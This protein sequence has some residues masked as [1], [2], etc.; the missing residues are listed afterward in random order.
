MLHPGEAV[1][2]AVSG[3][4][5]SMCLL[6]VL[7]DLQY[8]VEIA[9]F[10]HQ[11][12][13][14]RS[15]E[16]AAFVRDVAQALGVPFHLESRAIERDAAAAGES[17]EAYA[18]TA[19]YLFLHRVA[20]A[21]GIAAIATGHQADD[22]AETVIMRL[23]RGTWP[24]G[25]ASIPPVR[26]LSDG[27]RIVRPLLDCSRDEIVAFV[28]ERNIGYREDESNAHPRFLR[29]RLRH[30][31]LPMLEREYNPRLRAA[32]C[33]LAEQ[34]QDVQQFIQAGVAELILACCTPDTIDR[35][36]F[37]EGATVCQRELLVDCAERRE[38]PIDFE[39][40]ERAR[41][42]VLEGPSH[43]SFDFG[44]GV[45][46]RNEGST[47][48]IRSRDTRVPE[49]VHL[50]VPGSVEAFGRLFRCRVQG[51]ALPVPIRSICDATRQVFDADKLPAT[52]EVRARRDG[53][54]FTPLGMTAPKK[55]KD[56]FIDKKVPQPLRDSTPLLCAGGGVIWVVGHGIDAR[57]AVTTSTRRFLIIEVHD[58]TE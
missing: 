46:L 42:F 38:I 3:G 16:D 15:A 51:Q 12:R 55:L 44:G 24:A 14:G 52:L 20:K 37:A 26:R 34:Q 54:R 50:T 43:K 57:A 7:I 30:E 41:R 21:S 39:R 4:V 40:I 18:R 35:E 56:Y 22:R 5:D 58:A 47:T 32:L 11:T 28:R 13:D 53:D 2:V 23:L 31:L 27:E 33:R 49:S 29:N 48:F 6:H 36:K 9:H 45:F 10:D 25:L 19:R 8:R 17:F 1:L